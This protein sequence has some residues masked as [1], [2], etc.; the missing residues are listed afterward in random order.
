MSTSQN[1]DGTNRKVVIGLK[2]MQDDEA[3]KYLDKL[4]SHEK[5]E[6]KKQL[7]SAVKESKKS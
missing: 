6:G 5:V 7:E 1:M 2:I 4:F 3:A